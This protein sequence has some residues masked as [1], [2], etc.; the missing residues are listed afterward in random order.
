[1]SN[2]I[3]KLNK[4]LYMWTFSLSCIGGGN[5]NPLQCSC[6]E[7]PRDGE[8]WWAAVYG[9][10]WSR[11]RLKWLSSSSLVILTTSPDTI[12]FLSCRSLET[13]TICPP[14]TLKFFHFFECTMLFHF[15]AFAQAVSSPWNV[16]SSVLPSTI[17][18]SPYCLLILLV[19][20]SAFSFSGVFCA[21]YV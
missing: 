5:G 1:M 18:S 4:A 2:F 7:N 6:L 15:L 10:A 19:P 16:L 20:S 12:S 17:P 8:A 21:P 13:Q 3:N 9:V 14:I 11:T